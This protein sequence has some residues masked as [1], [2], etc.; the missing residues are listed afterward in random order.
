MLPE[1]KFITTVGKVAFPT[2]S[3]FFW[4]RFIRGTFTIKKSKEAKFA[5]N[6]I[7][8]KLEDLAQIQGTF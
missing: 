8:A 2:I 5:G 1:F 3:F 6:G 4:N 7:E